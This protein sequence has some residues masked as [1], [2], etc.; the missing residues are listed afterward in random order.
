MLGSRL[1]Q[2]RQKS[3]YTQE[4]LAERLGIGDRQIWRYE[5][6]A[7]DMSTDLLAKIADELKVSSD[8]LLGLVDNPSPWLDESGLSEVER[9]IVSALRRG[10]VLDAVRLILCNQAPQAQ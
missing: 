1:R 6:N 7:T 9:G 2:L 3:G 5:T 10:D 8:Y 4:Q